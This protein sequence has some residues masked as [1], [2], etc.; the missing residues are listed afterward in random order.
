MK[1]SSLKTMGSLWQRI[2][3]DEYRKWYS[4]TD[5]NVFDY[6]LPTDLLEAYHKLLDKK[7]STA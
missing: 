4:D 1:V 2:P 6:E 5:E 3:M 7:F